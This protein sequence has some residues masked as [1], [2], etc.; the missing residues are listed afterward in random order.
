[1]GDSRWRRIGRIIQR[2]RREC[3]R[4]SSGTSAEK[5]PIR[6]R[7]ADPLE[8]CLRGQPGGGLPGPRITDRRSSDHGAFASFQPF[9]LTSNPRC[10]AYSS[11]TFSIS[12]IESKYPTMNAAPNDSPAFTARPPISSIMQM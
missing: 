4:R 3:K 11:Y 12:S 5:V 1:M 9:S 6:N 8:N 10:P 7:A 2:E